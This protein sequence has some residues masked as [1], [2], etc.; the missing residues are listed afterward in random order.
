MPLRPGLKPERVVLNSMS[1][2]MKWIKI[3]YF[4]LSLLFTGYV[5][6]LI[7]MLGDQLGLDTI[8]RLLCKSYAVFYVFVNCLFSIL[9][10]IITFFNRSRLIWNLIFILICALLVIDLVPI[11]RSILAFI[12]N[13]EVLHYPLSIIIILF[14]GITLFLLYKYRRHSGSYKK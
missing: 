14:H 2:Y 13:N 3:Y 6:V 7:L 10:L 1:Q 8:I 4:I 5:I 9:V 11:V 12:Q